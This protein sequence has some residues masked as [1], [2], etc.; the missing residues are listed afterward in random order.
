MRAQGT[1]G[2]EDPEKQAEPQL[3][4]DLASPYHLSLLAGLR[5]AG[6]ILY[7]QAG[8]SLCITLSGEKQML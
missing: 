2:T 7:P 3:W 1:Q 8:H 4:L 5:G 6:S